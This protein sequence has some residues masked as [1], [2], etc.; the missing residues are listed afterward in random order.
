MPV[1]SP[2]QRHLLSRF[3][4]GVTPRLVADAERAGG[5]QRWFRRQLDHRQIGDATADRLRDWF[6]MIWDAAPVLW[7]RNVDR[8]YAGWQVSADLAR[9]TMLRRML[10]HRQV[11]ESMVDFWSNLLHVSSP[12]D[13]S[14][15][16]RTRYDAVIR[17][18]ALGRFDSMLVATITHPAMS[19]YLDNAVSTARNPNENLG[20]ELLELHTVGSGGGY[21]E[22]DVRNSALILTG[23][24]VDMWDS[25]RAFYRPEIHHVGTVKVLG[26]SDRNRDPD[27]RRLVARY[28]RYLAHHPATARRIA[29]RLAVRFVRDDPSAELVQEVARVFRSSGTDIKQ[30]LR[31]LVDHPDFAR[32]RGAKVRTPVEDVIATH[33]VLGVKPGRPTSDNSYAKALLWQA[34]SVGQAPFDWPRPDGFPDVAAAWTG[35]S[36][37]LNSFEAHLSAA[38]GWWPTGQVRYREP[39]SFLPRLPATLGQVVEHVSKELLSRPATRELRAAVS[40]KLDLRLDHELR[41]PDEFGGWRMVPLLATVLDT[42]AHMSR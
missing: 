21:T 35:V 16:Y 14:W 9:W 39:L 23:Y 4:Y 34:N 2:S 15:L 18:H 25:W 6:P 29:R 5:A 38:G 24:Y 37:V 36:R 20:R 11:H 26:F 12:S 10:S 17:R 27:G 8:V 22:A 31:A 3:S 41:S 28:L 30:T 19:V 7:Q 40:A 13:A 32:S 1:P 42:P 33:R